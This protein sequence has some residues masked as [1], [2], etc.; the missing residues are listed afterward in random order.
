MKSLCIIL[1]LL[2]AGLTW[3]TCLANDHGFSYFGDFKYSKDVA[4]FGYVNP[5]APKGGTVRMAF[6]GTFNNLNPYAGKGLVP[7]M[8]DPRRSTIIYDTLMS[9]SGDEQGVYYGKL[10]E[11]VEVAEDFSQVTYT[12]R[13]NAYWHDGLPI[14]MEDVVWTFDTIRRDA[15]IE[16]RSAYRDIDRLEVNGPRSFTFHFTAAAEKNPQLIIQTA[17]FIPLPKHYWGERDITVTTMEQPVGS[18]PYKIGLIDPGHKI[19]FDRVKD[20]WAKDLNITRGHYNFDHIE[21]IYFF[22]KSVM[23]QALR[24]GVF[25]YYRDQNENDFATAYDFNGFHRGLFKKETYTMGEAYGMHEAAVFNTRREIFK[26]IRVREALTLAYNFEWANRVFWHSSMD[27]NNSYFMRSGLQASGLPSEAELA[28]LEPFRDHLPPRVFTDPVEL[29]RNKAEGRNRDT[30][31]KADALLRE[32]GWVV[33]DFKRVH[34]DTGEPLT[35]EF[36]VS[37]VDY[38][39]MLTPYVDNLRRLG[40]ET[41]LRKVEN[42]IMVNRMRTYDYDMTMRKFYTYA[43]PYPARLRGQ[44]TSQYAPLPNMTNYAGIENPVVDVLVE[45]VAQAR[46]REQMNTAG[47]AL[48]R[49][50]LWNFYLI[51]DGHP[52]GRHL[53]YWDRFGHPPLGAEYM[54]WTGFPHLWWLDEEKNARVEAGISDMRSN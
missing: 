6:V 42:N 12:L 10:A 25:D 51:P 14:T 32:A 3:Q 33:R 24:G 13:E 22:D 1:H 7:A 37:Y 40:I 50:L 8:I 36:L 5:N 43:I 17:G 20:Y 28:L 52:V 53:V 44:F 35:F 41:V 29:P 16:W 4:H 48:D 34:E 11:K 2:A 23:L 39:R 47:R 54:T 30:L 49:V 21:A 31:L 46:T 19:V 9:R 18:G 27:R 26:D 38:E 45:A 15:T